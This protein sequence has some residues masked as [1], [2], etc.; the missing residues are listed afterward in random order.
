MEDISTNII[1]SQ[2][3]LTGKYTND[4]ACLMSV[5]IGEYGITLCF[6]WNGSITLSDDAH[7]TMDIF[8]TQTER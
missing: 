7:M 2:F 1:F 6:E 5:S 3:V 8:D 4:R